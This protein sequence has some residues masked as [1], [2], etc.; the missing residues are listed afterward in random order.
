MNAKPTLNQPRGL[1]VSLAAAFSAVVAVGSLSA[2]AWLFQR[3]GLPF[4]Q[5]VAAE[6]ACAAHPYA[7]E[8]ES[9][10]KDW[11]AASKSRRVASK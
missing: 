4:E 9:C 8:R 5:L 6:R 7:S 2:V 3:E 1:T 11:L 10:I